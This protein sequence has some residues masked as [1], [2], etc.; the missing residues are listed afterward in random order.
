MKEIIS[1]L[2]PNNITE[3][4]AKDKFGYISRIVKRSLHRL[5]FIISDWNILEEYHDNGWD[6]TKAK[7]YNLYKDEFG[8]WLLDPQFVSDKRYELL[9]AWDDLI[10]LLEV[11]E[12]GHTSVPKHVDYSRIFLTYDNETKGVYLNFSVASNL[13]SD[14]RI[15]LKNLTTKAQN[16]VK[17][18]IRKMEVQ[19]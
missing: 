13:L 1:L 12:T 5:K 18:S 17:R 9:D 3:V 2:T 7:P 19:D 8:E 15:A 11:L 4:I 16:L 10:Y 6:V 14:Y